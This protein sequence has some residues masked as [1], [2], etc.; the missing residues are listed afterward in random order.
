MADLQVTAIVPTTCV[1]ERAESLF[2]AI[3]SLVK[4]TE[5]PLELL[6]VVNGQRV[7]ECLYSR[8]CSNECVRVLRIDEGSLPSAMLAGREVVSTPY[9]C[10]L[11]DDDEYLPGAIDRRVAV[12]DADPSVDLVVTNGWR[13]SMGETELALDRMAEVE[14]DPLALLLQENWLT[15]CGGLYRSSRIDSNFFRDGQPYMEWTWLAFRL[16]TYGIS[17]R[18]VNEPT[19]VIHNTPDS[20]SKTDNYGLSHITLHNR[21]LLENQRRD[22][23][24]VILKRLGAFHHNISNSYLTKGELVKAWTH[25]FKSLGYPNGYK[26]AKFSIRLVL[27]MLS[28]SKDGR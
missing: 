18:V 27:G 9:F 22:L 4:G 23:N 21:M 28:P 8:L 6:V 14:A 10:F 16:I 3:D 15:S 11:D 20:A 2:R 5:F 13:Q 25:H 7:D 17:I 24:S 19:F 12:L 26:Y 1:K